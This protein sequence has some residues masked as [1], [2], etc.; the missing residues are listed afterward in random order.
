MRRGFRCPELLKSHPRYAEWVRIAGTDW[1][2][3]VGTHEMSFSTE[4]QREAA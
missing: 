3:Y 4:A 1:N 2:L